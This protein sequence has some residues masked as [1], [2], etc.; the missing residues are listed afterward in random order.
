MKFLRFF[1]EGSVSSVLIHPDSEHFS[2][3]PFLGVLREL[4]ELDMRR[5]DVENDLTRIGILKNL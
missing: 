4:E 1:R 5:L 2:K 3:F